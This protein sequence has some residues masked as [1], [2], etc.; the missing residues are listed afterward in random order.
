MRGRPSSTNCASPGGKVGVDTWSGAL[1]GYLH[2]R[3]SELGSPCVSHPGH[4]AVRLAEWEYE[5][6]S[7]PTLTVFPA[8]TNRNHRT[9][10]R[11]RSRTAAGPIGRISCPTQLHPVPGSLEWQGTNQHGMRMEGRM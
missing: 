4:L 8:R 11:R 5:R 7:C 10:T 6:A 1:C 3:L 2:L 9:N